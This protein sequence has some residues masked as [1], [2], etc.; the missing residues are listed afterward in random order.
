MSKRRIRPIRRRRKP[1]G[2]ILLL[3]QGL[4]N[5][6]NGTFT[7]YAFAYDEDG[8]STTLGAKTITSDNGHAVKPFGAIDTPT[9]GQTVTT[10]F[11]NFGWR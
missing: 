11:F 10:S 8:H 2:A 5:Q 6:G 4:W 9:Y 1:A 7:L 3:T